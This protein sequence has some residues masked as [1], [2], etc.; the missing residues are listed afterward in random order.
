MREKD[1]ESE[2]RNPR[3]KKRMKTRKGRK[4]RVG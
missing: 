4:K 3:Q 2:A 1:T